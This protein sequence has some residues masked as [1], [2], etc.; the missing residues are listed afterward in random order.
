MPR[1]LVVVE[2]HSLGLGRGPGG[3]MKAV[4]SRHEQ[5]YEVGVGCPWCEPVAEA[6]KAVAA[7]LMHVDASVLPREQ[8]NDVPPPMDLAAGESLG[9]D[10]RKLTVDDMT[11]LSR[12]YAL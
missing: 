11:R 2:M 12:F 5:A 7:T 6:P 3:V 1:G 8:C 9:F 4:C 10:S